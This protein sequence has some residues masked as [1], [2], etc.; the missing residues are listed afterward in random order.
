MVRDVSHIALKVPDL[1]ASVR[2]AVAVNGLRE[3]DRRDGVAFLTHG[4]EHHSL[5]LIEADHAALDHVGFEVGSSA[6]LEE[7]KRRLDDA[8]V[9][10][11]SEEPQEDGFAEALRFVAPGGFVFEVHAA[12]RRDQPKDYDTPG[13]RPSQ[14]GHVTLKAADPKQLSGFAEEIL[15]FRVSDW[16]GGAFVFMRCNPNHHALAIA[17]GGNQLHHY[18]WEVESVADQGRLGDHLHA[19]EKNLIWGPG[20][21][22]PGDNIFTY[23][24]DPA[25][26]VV[27]YYADL[28]IV[29]DES[30]YQPRDWPDV[31]STHNSWGPMPNDDFL[32]LGVDLADVTT[33]SASPAT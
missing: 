32:A 33:A 3:V 26:A 20:R 8:G 22:G 27:E 2:H 5:Q 6:Q 31:P 9:A 25:G 7:L 10:T 14:F 23:H 29:L 19:H 12:M 17:P 16:I 30:G 21:H 28:A 18:A 1:D 13:V 24:F 4:E 11:L 15:G